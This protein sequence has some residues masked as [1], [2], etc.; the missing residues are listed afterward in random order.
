MDYYK[1]LGIQPGASDDDIKKAYRKLASK[2]H[3]D[4]GGDTAKFQEIQ[5]AYDALTNPNS[6]HNTQSA[7]Q[8][9]WGRESPFNWE[10]L[11]SVFGQRH[12]HTGFDPF[13]NIFKN[14]GGPRNQDYHV[15]I[16]VDLEQLY[17]SDSISV[18]LRLP[19]MSTHDLELKLSHDYKD[20]TRIRYAGLGSKAIGRAAP[21]DLYV[22]IRQ[23]PH[24]RFE[25]VGND[26]I[27]EEK[28]SVWTAMTGG[29]LQI[30]TIDNKI[31][32]VK[33][34]PGTQQGTLM[35]LRGYGMPYG[36]N[37]LKGDML[38]RLNISI[39]AVS[40]EDSNK[41]INQLKGTV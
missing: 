37:G 23:R 12:A 6:T 16:T 13:D 4:K 40:E 34:N 18:G 30:N 26:L 32:E 33:I 1:V 31:L 17:R 27:I 25:R 5:A 9:N 39:P 19:S 29:D 14:P 41:T 3:P 20:G 8:Q 11:A 10:D 36:A 35:R 2:H 21:G 7:G 22:T 15:D 24:V 28:V 38:V